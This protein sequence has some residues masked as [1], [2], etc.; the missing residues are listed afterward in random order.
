MPKTKLDIKNE[1]KDAV[2]G[3]R[4]FEQMVDSIATYI[5]KN[6]KL[7]KVTLTVRTLSTEALKEK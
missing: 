4:N 5:I 1:I 3:N 6:Y 2:H 7:K